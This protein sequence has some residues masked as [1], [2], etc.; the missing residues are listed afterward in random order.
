M[1][2]NIKNNKGLTLISL[3]VA[4][5][6]LII[7]STMLVYN[8]K[9][10]SKMRTLYL[11]E[12]DI[13]LLNDKISAFYTKYGALPIEIQYIFTDRIQEINDAN[14]LNNKDASNQYYI[15][16]LHALDGITLNYGSDYKNV[17]NEKDSYKYDDIYFINAESHQIYYAK[18]V[19]V[20]NKTYYTSE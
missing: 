18:G 2:K 5:S 15:L 13:E 11:M 9:N 17:H 20:G 3:V 12:N 7:I 1:K 8:A 16:D 10:G 6:I 4:V 14:Q 19:K